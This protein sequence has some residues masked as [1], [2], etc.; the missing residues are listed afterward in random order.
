MSVEFKQ[1]FSVAN[2]DDPVVRLGDRPVLLGRMIL[3]GGPILDDRTE[4]QIAGKRRQG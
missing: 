1:T 3:L 4:W 2:D